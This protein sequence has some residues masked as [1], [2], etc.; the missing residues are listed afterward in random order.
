MSEN[1]TLDAATDDAIRVRLRTFAQ[2][3]AERTD[4]EAALERMPRR[5]RP[6]TALLLTVAAC[7]LAVVALAALL[8]ARGTV[9]TAVPS[10]EADCPS[11]TL[12]RSTTPGAN[13]NPRFT[14]RIAGATTA[15]MLIGACSDEGPTTLAIGE[16]IELVGEDGLAGQTLDIDAQEDAGAVTGEVLFTDPGGEV[17]VT[18]ECADTDTEGVVVLGGTIA[19]ST[20]DELTGLVALYIREGEP[21][22]VAIWL[23]EGENA[24]C[25]ALLE[26]RRD[27]IDDDS[28]FAEVESGSDIRTG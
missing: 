16:D 26:N 18:I 8:P 25:E 22:Q 10:Q 2:E 24:S 14:A 6:P 11:T 13:M 4:T 3:V 21:D 1:D 20:D 23:D 9:A 19:E 17:R 28:Q 7:L 15:L 12:P 5:W 27:V